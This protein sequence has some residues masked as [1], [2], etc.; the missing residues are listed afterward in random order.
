MLLPLEERLAPA[1]Y[2]VTNLNDMGAGSLRDAIIRGDG[3][4]ANDPSV[5][6]TFQQG[7]TGTITLQSALQDLVKNFTISGPG[8]GSLTVARSATAPTKFRIFTL[9]SPSTTS[10][11]QGLTL[12]GG[13][14][15]GAGLVLQRGF[16]VS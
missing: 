12:S 16:G 5:T 2:T 1:A 7:L 10:S 14:S 9:N 4:N 13:D 3:Q 11:I 6:I 15:G 8:S